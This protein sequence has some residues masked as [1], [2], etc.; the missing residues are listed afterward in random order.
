MAM[1]CTYPLS[2]RR[3]TSLA[4]GSA[5]ATAS[6]STAYGA[7][8]I[9]EL[10]PGVFRIT[11]GTPEKLTPVRTRRYPPAQDALS[12]LP[13]AGSYPLPRESISGTA[14]R[15]GFIV[16]LPLGPDELVYGLGLQLQSFLQ[17]GRKKLLRVNADPKMDS[18]DSHAPVP[19][20]VST[21]GY[22]VFIDTARYA[23][24]YCGN[25]NR[26][27]RRKQAADSDPSPDVLPGSTPAAY[28]RF[29]LGERSEV[30]IEVPRAAGADVYIFAGPTMRLAIQRYN[31]F[32]GGG[33]LPPRWGLGFWYRCGKDMNQEEVLA[34]AAGFRD[35][36]IPCDVIGLEPGW[37]SHTYSCSFVWNKKNFPDP[38]RMISALANDRYRLNL[39]EH[40]YVHPSSPI[41]DSLVPFS[42]DYEVWGGLVPDFLHPEA[43]RIFADFHDKEH[44]ALGVAGYKLDECDN[45]DLSGNWSFPE[46]SEFP[47]GADGEQMHS[48]LG[49]RY[50]DTI[51]SVFERRKTRTYGLVRSSHALAAPYPY[52]LYSDLYDHKEYIRALANSG[53]SGLL[54]TPEVRDARSTEDLIRRLQTVILSPLA[55]VDTW[56]MKN[57]PWKQ[58]ERRAN[59][60]G[61]F[62]PNWEE[63]EAQCRK[64]IELRMRLAP[65][66]YAAFVRYH[67]QG[68]PPFRALVVDY[69]DDPGTW[70][71]DDQFLMGESLLVAPVTA[72]ETKRSVY[73]P[74]GEWFDFWSGSAH[75]GKTRLDIPV[76]LDRVPIFVKS[77]T[78]LP[79]AEPALHTE[80]EAGFQLTVQVYGGSPGPAVLY[81]DDGSPDPEFREVTLRWDHE[82]SSV[83]VERSGRGSGKQYALKN[84]QFIHA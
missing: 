12:G 49:L 4:A 54:W 70:T 8:E 56:Y 29:G 60:A 5:L 78:M 80:D 55:Q 15:G 77:G 61:Q 83:S 14:R 50:Q 35:R 67:K 39:W 25:K 65:Y 68:I 10:Y 13:A 76:P 66:L 72:G 40:A 36:R 44:I 64:L 81:E 69:P 26:K 32:S 79:L 48:F 42:G 84:W 22:G 9:Q 27:T 73:L 47:S 28:R 46:I 34:L 20:Y 21:R 82:Q 1:D 75:P 16:S 19:F 31:L 2:R 33:P 59:S 62:S 7:T 45:S 3:F 74:Q 23:T 51:Q 37:Q 18:G 30:L 17:R 52:V 63:V 11:L 38:A 53:F 57:P 6:S 43:R 71:I 58:V 24:F 41:Y